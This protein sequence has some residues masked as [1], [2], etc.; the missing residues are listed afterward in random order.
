LPT[1]RTP[2]PIIATLTPTVTSRSTPIVT[3]RGR[4]A[5]SSLYNT[6]ITTPPGY[7]ASPPLR[8]TPIITTRG[9]SA[10][11][12]LYSAPITT[13]RGYSTSPTPLSSTCGTTRGTPT[14][15]STPIRGPTPTPLSTS[16]L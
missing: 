8:S 11:P 5:F 3:T 16:R 6:S 12:P 13:P 7:K 1:A 10:S 4:S 2:T 14:P 9:R 15:S